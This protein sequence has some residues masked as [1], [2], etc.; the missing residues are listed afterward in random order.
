LGAEEIFFQTQTDQAMRP[1]TG[2]SEELLFAVRFKISKAFLSGKNGEVPLGMAVTL[3]RL[4]QHSAFL[5][6]VKQISDNVS[7]IYIA[8]D[9]KRNALNSPP[10]ARDRLQNEGGAGR[11]EAK[12]P[13]T[14]PPTFR[15]SHMPLIKLAIL[16]SASVAITWA[17]AAQLH[18]ADAVL[19]RYK[20]VLGGV[21]AIGKVQSE[22]VRGEVG[23]TGMTGKT[24]F[25][26]FAKPFKT[27]LKVTRP[28]G[29]EVVSGF[30]G[31]VSW[32]IDPKGASIDK[33]TALEAVRRDA[34]L[35]YPLHQPDYFKNLD[36]AGVTD[37]EGHR[38]YW[39]QG[40]TRWGKDNNQF[41]DVET[42]LLVGYRFQ[43][44]N[45]STAVMIVDFQD[46]KNFGGPLMATKRISH[47][48]DHSQTFTFTSVSYEPL[49]DSM[50]DLPQAVK[51][52]LK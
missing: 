3:R 32:S 19:D 13:M 25:V 11:S 34:D 27:L 10:D 30:D 40:T 23:G 15:L 8:G 16:I 6:S 14:F 21:D 22:T 39:L 43:V 41:Y 38:C 51:A 29:T 47:S 26:Y 5:N 18:T 50:F 33:D 9:V 24:T 20:Q 46:Y 44:D 45:A 37:F 48:G 17:Q 12:S 4:T 35:Q 2:Y 36:F 42:G 31:T 52:L 28:N 7:K 49:A 1:G